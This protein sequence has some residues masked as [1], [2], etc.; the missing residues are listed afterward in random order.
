[1]L[2]GACQIHHKR[3]IWRFEMKT[4]FLLVLGALLIFS[5]PLLAENE[6][7]SLG[8][9]ANV[10][11][12]AN[13]ALVAEP[14]QAPPTEGINCAPESLAQDESGNFSQSNFDTL[15]QENLIPQPQKMSTGTCGACSDFGCKGKEVFGECGPNM[16]CATSFSYCPSSA[17]EYNCYCRLVQAH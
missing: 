14:S 7:N 5:G 1:M 9:T 11:S 4:R 13:A 15:F 2:E 3:L 12:E 17:P 6:G 8:A 10:P 16:E